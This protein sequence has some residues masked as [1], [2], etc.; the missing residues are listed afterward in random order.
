LEVCLAA[1]PCGV[2]SCASGPKA[3][4]AGAVGIIPIRLEPEIASRIPPEG[5]SLSY[6]SA[7]SAR[8]FKAGVSRLFHD[9]R[10]WSAGRVGRRHEAS[11][12][13]VAPYRVS[14]SISRFGIV[15][16]G[17]G[18]SKHSPLDGKGNDLPRDRCCTY[19]TAPGDTPKHRA[20]A[21]YALT[22]WR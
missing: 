4:P 19:A 22:S 14:K 15:P 1:P 21:Y 16:I 2:Y 3:I 6:I 8:C 11:S 7:I 17:K 9:L 18:S 5:V 13:R 10:D 12:Q 20:R